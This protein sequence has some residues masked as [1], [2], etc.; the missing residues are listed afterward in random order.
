MKAITC[1]AVNG[2]LQLLIVFSF[3]YPLY[4][5]SQPHKHSLHCA[6]LVLPQGEGYPFCTCTD[7]F[8]Y[9]PVWTLIPIR[10]LET[11]QQVSGHQFYDIS[12]R[13][14][15]PLPLRNPKFY[16]SLTYLDSLRSPSHEIH[17]ERRSRF[18]YFPCL[19][20]CGLQFPS[21]VLKG[22]VSRYAERW[23]E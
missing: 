22:E 15:Y 4:L 16:I 3:L 6:S 2:I 8:A 19:L 23:S 9:H 1:K 12:A 14:L 17:A 21:L 18:Y 10:D 7:H 13:A 5:Q 20:R 11:D